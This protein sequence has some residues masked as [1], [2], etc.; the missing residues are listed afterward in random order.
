VQDLIAGNIQV[1]FD[2]IPSSA[3]A[4][5]GGLLR[6]LAVT[7]ATRAAAYPDLP[8]VAE[9][10]VPGFE[11]VNV[12]MS[13]VASN[14]RYNNHHYNVLTVCYDSSHAFSMER[15]A[16]ELKPKRLSIVCG[17]F[18]VPV[19]YAPCRW[20]FL[21]IRTPRKHFRERYTESMVYYV[22]D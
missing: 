21:R 14:Y 22:E 9:A 20:C 10:G 19:D 3:A 11:Y 5:R 7:T 2:S 1:M 6:P 8:T 18:I 13:R 15:E 16:L 4:V 17:V 12:S